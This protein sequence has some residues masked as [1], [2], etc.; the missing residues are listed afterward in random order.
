MC[1]LENGK[2]IHKFDIAGGSLIGPNI[3]PDSVS[4]TPMP[5]T[6]AAAARD[7]AKSALC[8]GVSVRLVCRDDDDDN[9][10]DDD[11]EDAKEE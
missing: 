7:S 11:F 6:A 4:G 2:R 9:D 5:R 1:A 3:I 10:D 8:A